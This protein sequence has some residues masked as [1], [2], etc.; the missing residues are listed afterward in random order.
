[1]QMLAA[2]DEIAHDNSETQ[3]LETNQ[4]RSFELCLCVGVGL[5]VFLN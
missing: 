3:I 1:M 5:C 2:N 4:N